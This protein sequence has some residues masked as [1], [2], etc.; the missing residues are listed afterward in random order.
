MKLAS[1]LTALSIA[2]C[3]QLAHGQDQQGYDPKQVFDPTFLSEPG[4]AYRSGSGAPGPMYWQ[5]RADYKID[6]SLDTVKQEISGTVEITY[7]NNSPDELNYLWLQLDQN[8][9]TRKSRGHNTTPIGGYRFG[10][11]EFEGG[12]VYIQ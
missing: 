5:N 2:L 10:N 12:T 6:A 8:L 9:F 11:V 3:C 7:S 4:T 1:A